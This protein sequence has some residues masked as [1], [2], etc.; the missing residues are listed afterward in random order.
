MTFME[1]LLQN[2][3][4]WGVIVTLLGLL[5]SAIWWAATTQNRLQNV[6]T[7]LDRV[8]D[9]LNN[10]SESIIRVEKDITDSITKVEKDITDS[11]TK[12]EK[13][14]VKIYAILDNRYVTNSRSPVALSA[15]GERVSKD[16]SARDWAD[17]YAVSLEP[18][19]RDLKEFEILEIC[20]QVV[21][22]EIKS[23]KEFDSKVKE[24]SYNHAIE[25]SQTAEVLVVEL[26]DSVLRLLEAE[27]KTEN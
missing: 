27:T 11:I 10:L 22:K 12:V 14:I 24:V 6:S 16:L 5:V 15:F 2:P 13:D 8:S 20:R 19:V 25:S 3:A 21:R 23:D 26:R 4:T 1:D 18:D 7:S 17:K 9:S